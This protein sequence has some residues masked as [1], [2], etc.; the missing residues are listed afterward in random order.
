[1]L[2]ARK[3]VRRERTIMRVYQ[4]T[5]EYEKDGEKFNLV[6]ISDIHIG[7]STCNMEA[8]EAT[9]KKHGKARNTL[10]ID[11]GDACDCII[12]KDDKR[13]DESVIHP[14]FRASTKLVDDQTDYYISLMNKYVEPRQ[15]LG[16][17][18][19]NHHETIRKRC[20]TDPTER[21]ARALHTENLGYC[22]YYRLLF[23]REGKGYQEL[24]VYG[25]HGWGGGCR[26]E[27]AS[28]TKYCNHAKSI[29]A[30]RVFLY[31]HDHEKWIK[32][33]PYPEPILDK[34]HA[35]D[36]IVADCG[37]FKMTLS[38]E[39]IPDY[40]EQKGYPL[41][42]IGNVIIEITTPT[43]EKPYFDLHGIV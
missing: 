26:T 25:N 24:I 29:R 2:E 7:S 6:P 12:R 30:A 34:V 11:N 37:T 14:V 1:M 31:A 43:E 16:L 32:A 3:A 5:I 17:A 4:R 13:Y 15:F 36:T 42:G 20:D 10:L 9:L 23:K 33:V 28:I 18:S 19:G 21:I 41:R 8:F 35:I 39:A 22:Y 40:G 38:K 27:G